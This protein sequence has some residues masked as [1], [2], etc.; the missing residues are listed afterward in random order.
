M[1]PTLVLTS[2]AK[3]FDQRVAVEDVSFSARSG[4]VT[5]LLG[6][7]GAGKTTTMRM[8][9]GIIPPD[10]GT[11]Q[12]LGAQR[13][14]DVR[15]RIGYLPEER[16]LYVKL[17]SADMLTYMAEL[18]GMPRARARESALAWLKRLEISDRSD[19]TIESL[20][21]GLAQ[22]VQFACALVHD[23]ELVVLDEPMSGLDPIAADAIRELIVDLARKE[24][25]TVLLSTHD[26]PGAERLCEDLVLIDHGSVVLAGET[27]DLKS[28]YGKSCVAMFFEGDPD[29]LRENTAVAKLSV[30]GNFADIELASDADVQ[31]LLVEAAGQLKIHRFELV[32]PSLVEIFRRNVTRERLVRSPLESGSRP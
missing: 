10:S 6:P 11:I 1:E 27:A 31:S 32:E 22:R 4:V 26:L 16:G 29:F 9:L 25:K 14:H 23:P 3:R 18:K 13:A 30:Y 2:L 28:R 12:I 21:K 8:A 5:G 7:N 15:R 20:S 17:R 24:G 19:T